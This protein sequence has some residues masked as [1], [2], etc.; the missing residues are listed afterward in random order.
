MHSF[1]LQDKSTYNAA[2]VATEG[3]CYAHKLGS[4]M[5]VTV[6]WSYYAKELQT[7]KKHAF[8]STT[9]K[10][11]PFLHKYALCQV[12]VCPH[13]HRKHDASSEEFVNPWECKMDICTYSKHKRLQFI[14]LRSLWLSATRL[15]VT[16]DE[17][18]AHVRLHIS[19]I[20]GLPPPP[21]SIVHAHLCSREIYFV[22]NKNCDPRIPLDS[23]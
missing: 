4:H 3:P 18:R 20:V 12:R 7:M 1:Q 2:S 23:C 9:S 22:R 11:I 6:L 10:Q 17:T 15:R 8:N 16:V 13:V 14:T 21:P 19:H 5:Q